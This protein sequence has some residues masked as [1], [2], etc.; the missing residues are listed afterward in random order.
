[1]LGASNL[2][3]RHCR[4]VR[5][6]FKT[7]AGL[8]DQQRRLA[9]LVFGVQV[10]SAAALV[11]ESLHDVSARSRRRRQE[12]RA[13]VIVFDIFIRYRALQATDDR[14]RKGPDPVS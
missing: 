11:D 5:G 12:R 3:H 2:K 13:A 10:Y 6:L 8:G 7:A 14:A 1:M 4:R 9:L